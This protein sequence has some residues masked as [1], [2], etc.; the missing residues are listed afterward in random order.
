MTNVRYPRPITIRR[1][2]PDIDPITGDNITGPKSKAPIY[3]E[4]DKFEIITLL[5]MSHLFFGDD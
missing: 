4:F 2:E 1:P 3:Q 5:V